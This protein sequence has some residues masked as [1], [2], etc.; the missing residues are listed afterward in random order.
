MNEVFLCQVD[1]RNNRTGEHFK[2]SFIAEVG[3]YG[4][5]E[6]PE[7]GDDFGLCDT[8]VDRW[9]PLGAVID[10]IS[11]DAPGQIEQLRKENARLIEP[12]DMKAVIAE[13]DRNRAAIARVKTWE[14]TE[15][16]MNGDNRKL[17]EL[18]KQ[19]EVQHG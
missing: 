16:M 2:Q 14:R 15:R 10:M 13:R 18:R 4:I 3:E 19:M 11:A 7:T 1:M 5:L 12:A 6:D 9:V 17:I 8:D